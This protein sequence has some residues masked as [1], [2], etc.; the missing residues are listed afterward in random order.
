MGKIPP[1]PGGGWVGGLAP[2][3]SILGHQA[4]PPPQ[5]VQ[6]RFFWVWVVQGSETCLNFSHIFHI[7]FILCQ[8]IEPFVA[9]DRQ[10]WLLAELDVVRDSDFKI[11]GSNPSGGKLAGQFCSVVPQIACMLVCDCGWRA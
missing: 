2:N 10:N 9:N 1:P 4:P 11:L 5:G 8:T 3:F 6:V 7:F